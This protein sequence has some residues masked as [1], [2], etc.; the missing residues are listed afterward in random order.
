[1]PRVRVSQN[2][3]AGLES[4]SFTMSLTSS[5]CSSFIWM[6][7]PRL[8]PVLDPVPC[9]EGRGLLRCHAV[10]SLLRKTCAS[11][12]EAV[13]LDTSGTNIS[14][15]NRGN[16]LEEGDEGYHLFRGLYQQRPSLALINEMCCTEQ[17]SL[18]H[19]ILCL[20]TKGFE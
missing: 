2:G 19:E 18:R 3:R 5:C 13:P 4:Q 15:S 7:P 8:S 20:P 10:L 11:L 17:G 1:M 9:S 16:N 12:T 14:N 6:S